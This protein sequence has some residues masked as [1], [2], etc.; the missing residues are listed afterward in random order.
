MQN[1]VH[2]SESET[3]TSA[4]TSVATTTER[5]YIQRLQACTFTVLKQECGVTMWNNHVIITA[6]TITKHPDMPIMCTTGLT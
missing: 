5:E 6:A 1:I 3:I 2:Y 4:V